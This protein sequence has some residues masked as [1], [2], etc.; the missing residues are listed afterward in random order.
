MART[1]K[2]NDGKVVR[3]A[4]KKSD[5]VVYS[6]ETFRTVVTEVTPEIAASVG[7]D[8]SVDMLVEI[9]IAEPNNPPCDTFSHHKEGN[10]VCVGCAKD[11]PLRNAACITATGAAAGNVKRRAKTTPATRVGKYSNLT[12]LRAAIHVLTSPTAEIDKMALEGSLTLKAM[13]EK[14]N[15]LR[16]SKHVGWADMKTIS[17]IKNHL[18]YRC[19]RGWVISIGADGIVRV[20]DFNGKPN[21]LAEEKAAAD[22]KAAE[23]VAEEVKSEEKAEEVKAA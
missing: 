2:Q 15:D 17:K 16:K 1:Q 21:K 13:L 11:F 8:K 20:V 7:V 6:P 12:E 9:G 23:K 19:T 18:E 3:K 10:E 22:A 14:A 4:G 5:A